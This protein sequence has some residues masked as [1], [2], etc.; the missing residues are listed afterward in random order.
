MNGQVSR[1]TQT[2]KDTKIQLLKELKN[3]HRTIARKK[4]ELVILKLPKKKAQAQMVSL[5][6]STTH[7]KN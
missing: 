6:N 4:T 2:I 7:L 1:K 5:M 3:L